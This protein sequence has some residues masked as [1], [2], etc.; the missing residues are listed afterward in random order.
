M[1][2]HLLAQLLPVPGCCSAVGC[3]S[4]CS[5]VGCSSCCPAVGC[6]SCCPAVGCSSCC[7]AAGCSSCRSVNSSPCGSLR[8][9]RT[10]IPSADRSADTSPAWIPSVRQ[11]LHRQ[12]LL[13]ITPTYY[14]S[15]HTNKKNKFL[16][17]SDEIGCIVIC[18]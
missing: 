9:I 5:A 4:C 2:Q 10:K 15:S 3:S 12:K 8:M 17:N 6:S 1:F 13:S 11:Y 18:I 7:P 16:I 14:R